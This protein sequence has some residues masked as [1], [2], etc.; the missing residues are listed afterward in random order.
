M[1]L[2]QYH[3]KHSNSVM[4]NVMLTHRCTNNKIFPHL[5][6]TWITWYNYANVMYLRGRGGNYQG[7][8]IVRWPGHFLFIDMMSFSWGFIWKEPYK[9]SKEL[10][11][12]RRKGKIILKKQ[13][14]VHHRA[15]GQ[16][17]KCG[18]EQNCSTC[19]R[20]T[21]MRLLAGAWWV[22]FRIL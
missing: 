14:K 22:K 3:L 11:R 4:S 1:N 2:A 15:R 6:T 5:A 9:S 17:E 12:Y 10:T 8:A 7:G 16:R 21:K 18:E 13:R 19:A 20:K